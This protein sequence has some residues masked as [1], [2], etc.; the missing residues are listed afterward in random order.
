MDSLEMKN[1]VF[2][3]RI[4]SQSVRLAADYDY[5]CDVDATQPEAE[6]IFAALPRERTPS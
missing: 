4:H 5:D 2:A 3:M 1:S 6:I